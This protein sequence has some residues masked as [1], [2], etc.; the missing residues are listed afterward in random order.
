MLAVLEYDVR[1]FHILMFFPTPF[2]RPMMTF[3]NFHALLEVKNAICLTFQN[4]PN[5]A[6]VSHSFSGLTKLILLVT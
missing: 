5:Y 3:S 6:I 4:Q 1:L 2:D